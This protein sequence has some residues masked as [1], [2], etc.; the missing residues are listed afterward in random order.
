MAIGAE[1]W[2]EIDRALTGAALGARAVA[3]LRRRFPSLS[4]TRCDASDVTEP[5]YRSYPRFDVHLV[6]S[7]DHCVRITTD[8]EHATGLVV[9]DRTIP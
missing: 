1:D 2:T 4:W 8:P 5:P 7:A 6:D 9:A 3:E